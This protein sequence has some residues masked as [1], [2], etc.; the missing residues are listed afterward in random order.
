[1]GQILVYMPLSQVING[2][3]QHKAHRARRVVHIGNI[4]D[5]G[6]IELFA[7]QSS[8][9]VIEEVSDVIAVDFFN[10]SAA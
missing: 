3:R 4:R 2:V 9:L 5:V 8:L 10:A 7:Q 1:M 6:A